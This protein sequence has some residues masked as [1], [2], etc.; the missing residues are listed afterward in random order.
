MAPRL[1]PP[2]TRLASLQFYA[3][4]EEKARNAKDPQA[5]WKEM[6][7]WLGRNDLFYLLVRLLRRP[8]VNQDW[9]FARCR[10]VEK[11]PNDYLDL[12]AREHYKMLSQVEPIP[13]PNGWRLHGDLVPGDE[14]FGCDGNVIH[15]VAVNDV[16]TDGD[17]FEIEFDDGTK[18]QAGTEHLWEVE[19]H[20]RRRIPGTFSHN[21][22]GKRVYREKVLMRT[23]EISRYPH[24]Q[25]RRL[26]IPV[27]EPLQL[28]NADLPIDPYLLGCW[29]GDGTSVNGDITCGDPELFDRLIER[30]ALLS[31]NKSPRRNAAVRCVYGLS[32]DLKALQVRGNKHI[33]QIYLRGS[34][35]QRLELLRGLMDTDG[36]C[37]TRGTATFVNINIALVDGVTELCQSLG[38]KP[39][40]MK[41]I[42]EHNGEPYPYFQVA[43][44]A[45]T[46]MC[47]FTIA[48]KVARCKSGSRPKARRYVIACNPVP[49]SPMRCIQVSALDGMY[50][51]GK[52]MIPTHNST[53]I[54]F[55]LTIQDVLKDPEITVGFFSFNRPTA[56]AFLVQIT[57]ELETNQYLKWLY[58]DILYA[59]PRK[60]SPKW[61]EEGGIIVRR[62]GNPKEAT[63]EAWGLVDGQPTGRHFQLRIYDDVV[64]RE[65]VTT[66]DQIKKTTEAW[67]L[68]ENLGVAPERGGKVRYIGTRYH[69]SDTY[70]EMIRRK[71]VDV[72]L[73]A[74][75]HNGRFDGKPVFLSEK[76]WA[77]MLRTRSRQSI[78]A[79]QLQNP[80]ADEDATFRPEWLRSYE[81]RPR[82]LNVY[83]MA[84]P[85][86]GRGAESDN[87]AMSVVG[88][89]SNGAKYLLD[90]VCHRMTLSQRW[91]YL[92]G[93]YRKWSAT[94][95]V[96]H[97]AV[98][99]ERYGAQSDDEYFQ[100]QML[101]DHRKGVENAVFDIEELNWVREGGQSKRERVERLEPD[102]R[103]S[104]FFLPFNVLH[105][106]RPA[107]WRVETDPEAKNFQEVEYRPLDIQRPLTAAQLKAYEG[108]SPDLIAKAIKCYD[109]DR[110]T[111]DLT[112]HLISEYVSFPYGRFKD[113]I[114]SMSR[115]YDLEPIEPTVS[116]KM[117]TDPPQFWDR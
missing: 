15:V 14:L 21:G 62:K 110:H 12:W 81:V 27:A 86:K 34:V 93:F 85:S 80:M 75:T 36:H 51:A 20:T 108:G 74:A 5:A 71:A 94:P 2:D 32:K 96:Q 83:I 101:L 24:R 107:T 13:T 43:F 112:V 48:R 87:T 79:Q 30:G 78:A 61:S 8:D 116:T 59:D 98:G 113:L 4:L 37:N 39:N 58:S 72:R 23:E 99:Y 95:G 41:F 60:E 46:E 65:S 103:N 26:A 54:T 63:I 29:L 104:R 90:G 1:E 10:E 45:Y 84:D 117:N 52:S 9:L 42:G 115:I 91:T 73:H 35:E 111:Y 25:D 57:R 19:R 69:L 109:Q 7:R 33:P 92:R 97:V 89:A 17:A 56:R 38:L 3:D 66:A 88:I 106:A 11:K 55:A 47:P 77:R 22:I 31:H 67:E 64:T 16:V 40:R 50:L 28:P 44:Q 100:E 76:T 82:T 102:F 53:I 68:S 18:I 6:E 114:D 49:P 70:S 105:N